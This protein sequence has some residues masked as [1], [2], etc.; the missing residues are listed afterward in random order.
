[1]N[2]NNAWHNKKTH[3]FFVRSRFEV[4][5]VFLGILHPISSYWPRMVPR[6]PGRYATLLGQFSLKFAPLRYEGRECLYKRPRLRP[7]FDKHRKTRK[8]YFKGV[9][10]GYTS[11]THE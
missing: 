4:D 6:H 10:P 2:K 5:S 11:E 3:T 1:M 9:W 7:D 8:K